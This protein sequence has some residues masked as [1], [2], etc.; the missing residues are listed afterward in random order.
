MH[1][2]P[3]FQYE[4]ELLEQGHML[5]A[6]VDEAGRGPLAGPV[7]AAA[8]ILPSDFFCKDLNDSK[9]LTASL[10]EKI[11]TK[12][13]DDDRVDYGVGI[14]DSEKID[15][16]NILQA[17]FEAMRTALSQLTQIPEYVLVD[18]KMQIPDIETVQRAIV[19]GDSLSGSI[20]AASIIAKV[21]RDSMMHDFHQQYPK[22]GFNKHKG[23]GTRQHME[24]LAIHGTCPIH[25]KSFAP[26]K[27]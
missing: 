15:K 6:G 19:R 2:D 17:T 10:R 9:K 14:I 1:D 20:A 8:V 11:F 24:M 22:Y 13:V 26:C 7:V 27:G 16:L 3:L 12:I 21:T 5:I 4:R 23:Y 25:R 18:G